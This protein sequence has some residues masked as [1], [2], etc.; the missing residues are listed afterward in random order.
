MM[1][2]VQN[3]PGSPA[4]RLLVHGLLAL[5][6]VGL[7]LA[8]RVVFQERHRAERRQIEDA[9]RVRRTAELAA[10]WRQ[11]PYTALAEPDFTPRFLAATNWA[12][13]PLT[14]LQRE[15]L[16]ERLRLMLAHLAEP[17]PAGY[18]R[19]RT[20]GLTARLEPTLAVR[21][22][23]GLPAGEPVP[24]ELA[25][26]E[27]LV[28]RLLPLVAG[29]GPSN[30]QHTRLTAVCL[31]HLRV[32]LAATNTPDAVFNGV[33]TLG[34]TMVQQAHD[35]GFLYA[36]LDEDDAAAPQV[37]VAFF[38]RTED[39]AQAGPVYFSLRWAEA[40]GQWAPHNLFSDMLVGFTTLF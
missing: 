10:S 15:R 22:L 21:T 12:A 14:P 26:P 13:L 36:G 34:F 23:L 7:T 32:G 20:G 37:L 35:P 2:L 4:P 28:A 29:T 11:L 33:T 25:R 38:A 1:A 3:P 40:D 6:A 27:E 5:A 17:T 16:A 39:P 31:D 9:G 30:R 8:A 19:L 18:L 24:A